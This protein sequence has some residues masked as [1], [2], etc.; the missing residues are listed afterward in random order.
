MN[1]VVTEICNNY[2]LVVDDLDDLNGEL[3]IEAERLGFL[4]DELKAEVKR[5]AEIAIK[6]T[7]LSEDALRLVINKED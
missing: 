1:E 3:H 2:K 4:T 7:F 5:A 6:S